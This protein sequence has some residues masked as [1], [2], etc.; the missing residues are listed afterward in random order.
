MTLV[1]VFSGGGQGVVAAAAVV[2]TSRSVYAVSQQSRQEL[3]LGYTTLATDDPVALLEDVYGTMGPERTSRY[4]ELTFGA[5]LTVLARSI[6]AGD[7]WLHRLEKNQHMDGGKPYVRDLRFAGLVVVDPMSGED[8]L[9]QTN[10]SDGSIPYVNEN[11]VERRVKR[12][13]VTG[14]LDLVMQD[15]TAMEISLVQVIPQEI[16]SL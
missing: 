4:A 5:T 16:E 7:R 6:P 9:L 3:F 14:K 12:N 13:A 11:G 10:G 8:I 1:L 15:A 2:G